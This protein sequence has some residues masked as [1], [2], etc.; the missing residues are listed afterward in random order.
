MSTQSVGIREFRDNLAKYL[1]TARKPLT[2]TRHGEIIGCYLPVKR[3]PVLTPVF[4]LPPRK[5]RTQAQK[6][7]LE[8]AR[9]SLQK[10]MTAAGITEDDIVEDFKRFRKESRR[11]ER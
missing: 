2:I 5:R 1:L 9:A 10:S 8:D 11:K 4:H 3:E 7:A 6:K